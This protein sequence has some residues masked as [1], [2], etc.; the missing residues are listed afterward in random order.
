MLVCVKH[1]W[2][3]YSILGYITY[4]QWIQYAIQYE[5]E[6]YSDDLRWEYYDYT[7]RKVPFSLE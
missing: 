2:G 5:S 3:I 1:S 6:W 4:I 7:C